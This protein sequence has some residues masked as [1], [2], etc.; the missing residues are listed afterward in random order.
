[1]TPD[2]A[3]EDFYPQLQSVVAKILVHMKDF[4]TLFSMVSL[5]KHKYAQM[6]NN[7]NIML[8]HMQ[9]WKWFTCDLVRRTLS[10]R[11]RFLCMS[12]RHSFKESYPRKVVMCFRSFIF[13]CNL[14]RNFFVTQSFHNFRTSFCHLLTCS[15]KILSKW[16]CAKISW[17]HTPSK[18]VLL[19]CWIISLC[20][21]IQIH[22]LPPARVSG[23]RNKIG[24]VSVCV[25]LS[26]LSRLNHLTYD[27][28]F[29]HGNW[30]WP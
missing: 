22:L 25:R 21:R 30:P 13:L 14:E 7:C 2:R 28:D 12:L 6:S 19:P 18:L 26:A 9:W 8:Y 5:W 24:S 29:C 23:R 17:K 10:F 1:M 27:L 4:S 16:K 15:R 11:H 20:C 3:Y